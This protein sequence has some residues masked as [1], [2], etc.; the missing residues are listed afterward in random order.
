MDVEDL[1][2]WNCI[3]DHGLDTSEAFRGGAFPAEGAKER[4]GRGG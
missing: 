1:V 2:L 3:S 4:A